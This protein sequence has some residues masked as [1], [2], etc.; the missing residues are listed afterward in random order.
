MCPTEGKRGEAMEE[1]KSEDRGK[2]SKPDLIHK[3]DFII[4]DEAN[5][6][7]TLISELC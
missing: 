4:R 2:R 5:R 6:K 1:G 3:F 7:L